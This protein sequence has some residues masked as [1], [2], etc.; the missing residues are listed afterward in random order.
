M[1]ILDVEKDN[2]KGEAT[3]RAPCRNTTKIFL[4]RVGAKEEVIL[5]PEGSARPQG[6]RN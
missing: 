6:T 4:Q 5:V 1:F 2:S 3:A